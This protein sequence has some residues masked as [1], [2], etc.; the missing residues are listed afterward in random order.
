LARHQQVERERGP[1]GREKKRYGTF[2]A[3]EE[4]EE[5]THRQESERA[6][7]IVRCEE[8]ANPDMEFFSELCAST[9]R[10]SVVPVSPRRDIVAVAA[11]L[12]ADHDSLGLQRASN[13]VCTL[14]IALTPSGIPLLY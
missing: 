8:V 6:H 7:D 9:I 10:P 13:L 4:E 5:H 2:R 1:I 3:E 14:E 12:I 11:L